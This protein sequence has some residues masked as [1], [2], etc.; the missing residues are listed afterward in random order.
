MSFRLPKGK[1]FE[2]LIAAFLQS[3]G[4][5]VERN[6]IDRQEEEV[7]E[8]D[9]ITSDYG[10]YLPERRLYE[11]KSGSWGFGDIFKI[12]GWLDYLNLESGC[13]IV[14]QQNAALEFYKKIALSLNVQV[15]A[16]PSVDKAAECLK[17][18]IT[19]ETLN[20]IDVTN[21]RFS[22]WTERNFCAS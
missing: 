18:C 8:L 11:A 10:N 17:S 7:L 6:V 13:L 2:E 15:V 4:Y 14:M 22:Y 12:R 21:W 19:P 16:I 20:I 3:H 1:E 5:Y 9:I